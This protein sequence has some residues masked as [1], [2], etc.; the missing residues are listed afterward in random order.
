MA[1]Q[2]NSVI[3]KSCTNTYGFNATNLVIVSAVCVF[4]CVGAAKRQ[5]CRRVIVQNGR[6]RFIVRG[7]VLQYK[8]RKSF[9]L[10]GSD[11]AICISG[12][13]DRKA[14]VCVGERCGMEGVGGWGVGGWRG[15]WG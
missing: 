5:R 11:I 7:K 12:Q 15:G 10:V 13:W 1:I 14:P 4:A 2:L 8:C 3:Y 6:S 9:M